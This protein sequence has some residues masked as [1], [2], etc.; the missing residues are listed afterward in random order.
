MIISSKLVLLQQASVKKDGTENTHGN[1][2]CNKPL[3]P[4]EMPAIL[5]RG[6]TVIPKGRGMGPG[7]TQNIN[8]NVPRDTPRRSANQIAVDTALAASRQIRRVG[9]G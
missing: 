5:Q 9:I 4:S 7:I 3:R 8:V 2:A 6:E 1:P